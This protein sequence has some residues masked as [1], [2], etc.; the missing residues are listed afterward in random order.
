MARA[1]I[2]FYAFSLIYILKK[3]S[4]YTKILSVFVIFGII[5]FQINSSI[6]PL[7]KSKIYKVEN[8]QNLFTFKGY[9]NHYNYPKIKKIVKDN[10]VISIGV[11]PMVAVYHDMN[12][13][14]GYHT[15]YPLSYKKIE[16]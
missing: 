7:I 10:R 12:V 14:D 9:Y 11:D 16:N 1:E 2:F 4:L 3:R 5:L 13:M 6:V 8:Y 15:I